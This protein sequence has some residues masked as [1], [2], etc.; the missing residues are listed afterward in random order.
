MHGHSAHT[1]QNLP[2]FASNGVSN[3]PHLSSGLPSGETHEQVDFSNA[4]WPSPMSRSSSGAST[5][6]ARQT[7]TF[8]DAIKEA[9]AQSLNNLGISQPNAQTRSS[10]DADF[11]WSFK[12]IFKILHV[13]EAV[14][15]AQ[16][17][18]NNFNVTPVPL[19]DTKST[20]SVS[21]HARNDNAREYAQS[22]SKA[23]QWSFLK[24][25]PIFKDIVE[26]GILVPLDTVQLWMEARHGNQAVPIENRRASRTSRKRS[27]SSSQNAVTQQEHSIL[28][29]QQNKRQRREEQKSLKSNTPVLERSRT[30]IT[31]ETMHVDNDA[32]APQPGEAIASDPT[33]PLLSSLGEKGITKSV[34]TSPPTTSE[35][36]HIRE[37]ATRI[38]PPPPPLE[39]PP[40]ASADVQSSVRLQADSQTAMFAKPQFDG[41]R[42]L[43][44]WEHKNQAYPDRQPTR[45]EGRSSREETPLSPTSRE[46]LGM[47]EEPNKKRKIVRVISGR[48]EQPVVEEAYRY[49]PQRSI[50]S[51]HLTNHESR[52][53]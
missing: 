6:Y 22:I 11:N 8:S 35:Q 49:A 14:G 46:L 12:H 29:E 25:D 44:R 43:Q 15:L 20:R 48:R 41:E 27:R 3:T 2:Q 53:W 45:D 50:S 47:A 37:S 9:D 26:E 32:W 16:P 31:T 4:A 21:R 19:L 36:D 18:S 10:E 38:P 1:L 28:D 52:R 30:P 7:S 42:K 5:P 34:Y 40:Y 13:Q 33:E 23:P 24:Q 51:E 39:D 17:L